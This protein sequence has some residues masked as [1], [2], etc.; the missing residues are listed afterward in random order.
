MVSSS[1]APPPALADEALLVRQLR[2]D[3]A[4][5]LAAALRENTALQIWTSVA[6]RLR[7]TVRAS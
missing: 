4:V 6:T 5:E 1:E 3:G 2:D 7:T